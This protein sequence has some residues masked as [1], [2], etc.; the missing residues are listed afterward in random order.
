MSVFTVEIMGPGGFGRETSATLEIPATWAEFQD[1][2]QKARIADDKTGY[3]F[4][5]L[6]CKYD[7]L[8]P[9]IRHDANLPEL[10][11]LAAR[12]EKHIQGDMDI[13]EAMVKIEAGRNKGR[14]IPLV[15]L[16]NMTFGTDR[17]MI[18][19]NIAGDTDLGK[20]LYENGFLPDADAEAIATRID[21]G[22]PTEKIFNLMGGEHR[23]ATGGVL[24]GSGLYIEWEGDIDERYIPGQTSCFDRPDAPVVLELA[25]EGKTAALDLPPASS[26]SLRDT[27]E[28]LDVKDISECEYHCVDCLIPAAKEWIDAAKDIGAASAFARELDHMERH[29]GITEYKAL[30]EAAECGDLDTAMRL[31]EGIEDCRLATEYSGP[32]DYARE[33]IAEVQG[34]AD[35]TDL[36]EYVNLYAFGKKVM[37]HENAAW[38]SYGVLTRKDG[39][40]I[41]S[42][43]ERPNM[44]MEMM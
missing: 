42:Q 9:H 10:N 36:S 35:A 25:K 16:I 19:G 24:T 30:L 17:C 43:A 2:K 29:G 3:L 4:E 21:G 1:A 18:A 38:T 44:E 8:R 32:E 37:E 26:A 39:G 12:I 41:L 33:Y 22:R 20:F 40:P 31:A 23:E 34:G 28:K 13:F 11:L 7:W 14:P 27:E 6:N 5:L 15:R